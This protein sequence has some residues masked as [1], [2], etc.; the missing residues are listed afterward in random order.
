MASVLSLPMN[1]LSPL[2][3]LQNNYS[4]YQGGGDV[5]VIVNAQIEAYRLGSPRAPEIMRR[6]ASEILMRRDLELL[7]FP[8]KPNDVIRQF[9]ADPSTHMYDSMAFSPL[10]Q[11]GNVLNLWR[12]VAIHPKKGNW[13]VIR[14]HLFEVIC[15]QNRKNFSYLI[16]FLAHMVQHPEQKP[17]VMIVLLGRQGTGKG[18]FFQLLGR[19]WRHSVLQ[20]TDIER[21]TGRFNAALG[22]NYVVVMDEALFAGDRRAQDRI[23]SLIT[24][25]II[26]I[27][28]KHQPQRIIDSFHRFFAA[29]NHEH[30]VQVDNDDRRYF[31]L[32]VSDEMAQ[33]E[34]Y[35][36]RL[37][38]AIESD[39]AIAAFIYT[40]TK[41]DLKGF[42]PRVAPKTQAHAEQKIL[43]LS[44]FEKYWHHLLWSGELPYYNESHEVW[45]APKFIPTEWMV[46][47]A[48]KFDPSSS[49]YRPITT[50]E[51]SK[52]LTSLCPMVEP[53]RKSVSGSL[54]RQYRGYNL[55]KLQAARKAFEAAKGFKVD[56]DVDLDNSQTLPVNARASGSLK[57]NNDGRFQL[58]A[59]LTREIE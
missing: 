36:K 48:N 25:P 21:V 28:E 1:S 12:P 16:R 38:A 37:F 3:T 30:F 18:A 41:I 10:S 33:N 17:G 51:V 31:I 45:S 24:E 34:V 15:S 39:D 20:V 5:W 23:K 46:Q 58:F 35:F 7:P 11:P 4:L 27:E 43:S 8:S 13:L 42:N 6:T 59:R 52:E 19:I 47:A 40:L 32:E 57:P 53:D 26:S 14:K 2:Q 9:Y 22:Q 49:R 56:W 50:Q 44:R 29:S 54:G 55:P